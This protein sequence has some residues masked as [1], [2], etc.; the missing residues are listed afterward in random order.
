[1]KNT[2]LS[3]V[4]AALVLAVSGVASANIVAHFNLDEAEGPTAFDG[5]GT[6]DLN[7]TGPGITSIPG[8]IG[9]ALNF[10]R[11]SGE[12]GS[13]AQRNLD[14]GAVPITNLPLGA[15][16][17]TLLI[18]T[19]LDAYGRTPS[20]PGFQFGGYGRNIAAGYFGLGNG[21]SIATQDK[22]YLYG[23]GGAGDVTNSNLPIAPLGEWG[24]YAAT[25]DGATV[26]LTS[27]FE[28]GGSTS[29][30]TF[31]TAKNLNTRLDNPGAVAISGVGQ[32]LDAG[33]QRRMDG[34]ADDMSIW[35]DV[36]TA[37]EI[38]AVYNGALTAALN[39]DASDMASLFEVH[40]GDAAS[41]TLGT[42]TWEFA[43]GLVGAEGDFVLSGSTWSVVLDPAA[44]TGL[45]AVVPEPASAATLLAAAGLLGMRRRR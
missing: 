16:E 5:V 6:N 24:F 23:W 14:G 4:T 31:S 34:R 7:L 17:R 20:I 39:Y 15:S 12:N 2:P 36:L 21:Y 25:Y 9:N 22:L 45:T 38:K 43:T 18:W 40:D 26:T 32:I 30:N 13:T 37:A 28:D 1:M 33:N 8:V 19:S 10:E 44:G 29:F 27:I 42:L 11:P 3:G 35:S 41:A